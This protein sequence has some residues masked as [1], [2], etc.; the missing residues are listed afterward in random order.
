[1]SWEDRLREAAYTSPGGTRLTFDYEAV[2]EQMDSK[3]AAYEFADADGTFVQDLGRSGRRYPLRVIVWG[4][5]CD[6]LAAGWMAALS[7]RGIGILEHPA[8]GRVEVVPMGRIRRRDD[9]VRNANQ[10]IIEVEFFQT[11]G[12]AYPTSTGDPEGE[13]NAALTAA[14]EAQAAQLAQSEAFDS[15]EGRADFLSAYNGTLDAAEGYLRQAADAIEGAQAQVDNIATSINRGI[16]VLIKDPLTL[17]WQTEQLL[18]SPGRYVSSVTARL[19]AYGNMFDDFTGKSSDPSATAT[20]QNAQL[21]NNDLFASAA[22]TSSAQAAITT[23]YNT[24]SEAIAQAE[25]ILSQSDRLA[26]WRDQEYLDV[27]AIDTG[28]TWQA[29]QEALALAAGTLVQISFGL[30]QERTIVLTGPRSII[31]LSAELFGE[32]DDRLDQLIEVNQLTNNEIELLPRGREIIY[33][34]D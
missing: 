34:V 10:S 26:E 30:A 33:Y 11:T 20:A 14:A 32:V 12:A 1:M 28:G 19:E 24:Q 15:A 25:V 31:D 6:I 9:F 8:Y 16:D 7:E 17:A 23:E 13:T 21:A 27:G 4:A 5:D 2:S 3:A 18:K 22:A 29:T